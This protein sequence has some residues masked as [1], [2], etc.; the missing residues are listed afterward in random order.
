MAGGDRGDCLR[1]SLH[2]WLRSV[3]CLLLRCEKCNWINI[4]NNSTQYQKSLTVCLI[5]SSLLMASSRRFGKEVLTTKPC[6]NVTLVFNT[7]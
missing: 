4:S 1:I 2:D 3:V 5:I 7:K 6:L